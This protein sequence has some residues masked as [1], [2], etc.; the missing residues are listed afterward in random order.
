MARIPVP[1]PRRA[2]LPISQCR[3]LANRTNRPYRQGYTD[4]TR[5]QREKDGRRLP[6]SLVGLRPATRAHAGDA[7]EIAVAAPHFELSLH[8]LLHVMG[9]VAV[10]QIGLLSARNTRVRPDCS[11]KLPGQSRTYEMIIR[12]YSGVP[13]RT[14]W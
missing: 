11:G 6:A 4:Q 3:Q 8:A 14:Y 9:H 13:V 1:K 12:M 10:H 2:R 5:A 7:R